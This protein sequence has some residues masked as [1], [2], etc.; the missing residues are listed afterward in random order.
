MGTYLSSYLYYE[1]NFVIIIVIW[2]LNKF[3]AVP[4]FNLVEP[5]KIFLA[6]Y[7]RIMEI[8]TY[9]QITNLLFDIPT[10]NALTFWAIPILY[11]VWSVST[12]SNTYNNIF[13]IYF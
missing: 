5:A 2:Y 8:T 10:V 6:L 4:A 1:S 9:K 13:P 12:C 7:L 3:C 11:S